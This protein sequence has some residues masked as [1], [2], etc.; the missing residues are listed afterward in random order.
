MQSENVYIGDDKFQRFLDHYACPTKLLTV[1]FKF[2]GA[3]CSP[4]VNLRPTDVISSLFPEE[5]QPR[6]ETKAEAELFFK[7]FMG[8]WDEMF[9]QI[10]TN[11][12]RLPEY[13]GNI[14]DKNELATF[15]HSR[16]D[17]I[18]QGFVE[19]FWGGCSTLNIPQFAAE[20]ISSLSDMAEAYEIL[21]QKLEKA[22]TPKDIYTVAQ[23]T[24]KTVLKT[25]K[26]LIE[27]LV[28]PHITNLERTVN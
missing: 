24:D 3:I 10:R 22:E 25:I 17:M 15:L 26:F 20:L 12:L 23:N 14:N 11:T 19:G 13:K 27:N 1:K 9:V 8:L 4:N 21:A 6:L 7:F 18:E 28:L 16:A 2:A 5:R